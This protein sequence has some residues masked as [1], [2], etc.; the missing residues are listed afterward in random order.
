MTSF[1]IV[2]D[3]FLTRALCFLRWQLVNV[4]L[5]VFVNVLETHRSDPFVHHLCFNHHAAGQKIILVSHVHVAHV[6]GLF[7]V[8]IRFSVFH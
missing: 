3:S 7:C 8:S 2:L 4:V 6:H 5:Q 1:L